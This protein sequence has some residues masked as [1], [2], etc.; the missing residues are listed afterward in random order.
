MTSNAGSAAARDD[1][2]AP[3]WTSL[4]QR[5]RAGDDDAVQELYLR[6]SNGLRILISRQL[7]RQDVHDRIHDVFIIVLTAIRTERLRDPESLIG[8]ARAVTRHNIAGC[9]REMSQSRELDRGIKAG[10]CLARG[11]HSPE[12][13][14]LDRERTEI[15]YKALKRLRPRDREILKRFYL[16]GQTEEKICDEMHLTATQFR[17]AKSRAKAEFGK[18]GGRI[19]G[20]KPVM[21]AGSGCG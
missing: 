1:G 21:H 6:L 14:V 7:G 5:I 17:L 20:R 13:M 10:D 8:F 4:V 12:D 3:R 9:I 15:A 16:S 19:I 11:Q 2:S 18:I